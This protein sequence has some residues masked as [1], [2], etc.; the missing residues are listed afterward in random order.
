MASQTLAALSAHELAAFVRARKASPIEV[1]D[2]VLRRIDLCEPRLN[3]FVVLD[4][5]GAR[6]AAREVEAAVMRGEELGPLCGVPV[7]IKDIQ[8]VKGLPTRRGSRPRTDF[9][10]LRR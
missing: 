5:D 2:D 6:S 7:T 10:I 9:G 1:V 8:D 3:A 4:R